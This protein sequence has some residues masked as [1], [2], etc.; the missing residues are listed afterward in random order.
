VTAPSW[1]LDTG[2]IVA[3]TRGVEAVGRVLVDAADA[4]GVVAIPMICLIE[5]YSLVQYRDH[6]LLR[7]LRRNP[8]VRTYVPAAEP[9]VADDCP[10]IG[11][12]ARRAGRVGAGHTAYLALSNAA[13]VVTAQADEI[14]AVLGP[15]WSLVEVT[16]SS[17][18]VDHHTTGPRACTVATPVASNADRLARTSYRTSRRLATP[19]PATVWD[20]TSNRS[21]SATSRT[22]DVMLPPATPIRALPS[23]CIRSV[24][25]GWPPGPS[26]STRHHAGPQVTTSVGEPGTAIFWP[27]AR[28]R[29]STG[30]DWLVPALVSHGQADM[31]YI[32]S[33]RRTDTAPPWIGIDLT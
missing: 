28:L 13:S 29:S 7:L 8:A 33:S 21:S 15:E 12:M 16:A 17:S 31:A 26:T 6:E 1:V 10:I 23:G 19:F 14:R 25:A 2:A 22:V 27:V 32:P 3:F 24:R 20:S 5:A 9:G 30:P 11:A 4:E 18:P